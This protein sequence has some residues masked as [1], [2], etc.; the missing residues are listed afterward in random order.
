MRKSL[1]A[2]L[3][4]EFSEITEDMSPMELEFLYFLA[5]GMV[6]TRNG[7]PETLKLKDFTFEFGSDADD[8][9]GFGR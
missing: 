9:L 8:I 2:A 6:E 4:E 5:K 7:K 1:R 3:C